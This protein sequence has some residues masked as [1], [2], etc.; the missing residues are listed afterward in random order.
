MIKLEYKTVVNRRNIGT[1]LRS[2][3]G[4]SVLKVTLNSKIE[5]PVEFIM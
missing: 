5:S 1:K 2:E 3:G 4:F